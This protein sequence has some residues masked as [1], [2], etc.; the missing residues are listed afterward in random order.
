MRKI[1]AKRTSRHWFKFFR[2]SLFVLIAVEFTAYLLIN[3]SLAS[4]GIVI[5]DLKNKISSLSENN[6][7]I[8]LEISNL[9]SLERVKREAENLKMVKSD[10][11]EYLF[12]P[13]AV[14]VAENK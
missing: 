6:E 13:K 8:S 4:S 5:K 9:A 14:V 1:D 3:N 7:K 12:A 2:I 11:F 10:K